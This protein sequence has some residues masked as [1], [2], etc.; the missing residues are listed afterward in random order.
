MALQGTI[1]TFDLT[2]VVK[3][4]AAGSKT[5]RLGLSGDRGEGSV[6]FDSGKIVASTTDATQVTGSHT[7]V[8]FQLLRFDDGSFVFEQ[9]ATPSHIDEPTDAVTVLDQAAE[10]LVEWREIEAVVP[11][12]RSTVLLRAGLDRADVVIDRERWAA[13]A[14]VGGG[15]MVEELG[16]RLELDELGTG[17]VVKDLSELGLVEVGDEVPEPLPSYLDGTLDEDEA[18]TDDGE[19]GFEPTFGASPSLIPETAVEE[20]AVD[21]VIDGDVPVEER[22]HQETFGADDPEPSA[23][24]QL[25]SLASGFG[26]DDDR[27]TAYDER[28]PFDPTFGSTDFADPV[29]LSG[30][31]ALADEPLA[32][33]P[34]AEGGEEPFP[35]EQAAAT[36]Q[37]TTQLFAEAGADAPTEAEARFDQHRPEPGE[38][39]EVA[40]QLANL[41]PEAARAVAAAARATTDEE[42]E[43]ALA[44]VAQNSDQPIDPDLLRRFLSSVRH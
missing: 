17:R 6:W 30:A 21:E 31:E 2:E 36:G 23:R 38:A 33:E 16:D 34:L 5:G 32:D 42:R 35:I 19:D 11:S 4:L 26:I 37:A 9:G 43:A 13:L 15:V 7:D 10:R 12:M 27:A 28:E 39:A 8:V 29:P 1:D 3:M 24:E 44:Q 25:D 14:A 41:S 20:V 22:A 40:R 18:S